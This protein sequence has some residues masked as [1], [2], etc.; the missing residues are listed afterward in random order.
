MIDIRQIRRFNVCACT[1]L[2]LALILAAAPSPASEAAQ[3]ADLL[4]SPSRADR[5]MG[6]A[7]IDEFGQGLMSG[8]EEALRNG[9]SDTRRGAA[10]GLSLMPIPALTVESLV[11]GLG[12]EDAVVRSLCAHGLGKIGAPASHRT[13]QLLTHSDN[14]VRV[15]AALALTRMGTEA[16]PALIA[17]LELQDPAVTARTAWLL[18]VMGRDAIPAVPALIRALE[19]DDM[20]LLHLVAETIDAIGPDPA[21]VYHELTLLGR[22]RVNCPSTRLGKAAAPTLVKLLA[23]PGTPM[24]NVALYTLSRMGETA[25]PALRLALSTGNPSQRTAAALL[26]TGIDPKLVRTL[27]EDLRRS[28]TGAMKKQ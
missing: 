26:I 3:V 13:A 4:G 15:G 5:A 6:V 18:G 17:M 7:A 8:L 9:D 20:R 10:I 22:N 16:L 24:A 12:D 19:T 27:P 14:R 23:R 28:L 11:V 2:T 1:F 21:V 25:E